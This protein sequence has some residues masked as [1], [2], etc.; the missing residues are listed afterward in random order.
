MSSA[1][2][3]ELSR[4]DDAIRAL[5][6]RFPIG[7]RVRCLETSVGGTIVRAAGGYLAGDPEPSAWWSDGDIEVVAVRWDD[8]GPDETA[9]IATDRLGLLPAPACPTWCRCSHQG[10]VLGHTHYLHVH[11]T[12]NGGASMEI[13]TA[14]E[15]PF[16]GVAARPSIMVQ[17]YAGSIVNVD[18]TSGQARA[19]AVLLAD[20]G[21]QEMADGLT[22]A[23][24]QLDRDPL[25][26]PAL[27]GHAD[28]LDRADVRK[29]VATGDH[30]GT[31][32]WTLGELGDRLRDA[33]TGAALSDIQVRIHRLRDDL[34]ALL[35][36]APVEG[37]QR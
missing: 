36:L 15:Q 25:P 16:D 31:A 4:D 20:L 11:R 29:L 17:R 19:W 12:Y 24:D 32:A 28:R 30:L 27:R 8:A 6:D 26:G 10:P 33:E 34:A 35:A 1:T 23:A 9:W 13:L 37:V 22:E 14:W 7:S 5:T 18:L 21:Q 3:P 2:W